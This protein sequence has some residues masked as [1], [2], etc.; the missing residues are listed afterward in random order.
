MANANRAIGVSPVTK[1][2]R[3]VIRIRKGDRF[4]YY[5]RHQGH[6]ERLPDPKDRGFAAEYSNRLVAN[7]LVEAA[8]VAVPRQV[9]RQQVYFI[10]DTATGLIKIGIAKRPGRRLNLLQVGSAS[11]LRLIGSVHGGRELERALH[12]KF[13]EHR[14]R[15]E[16]FL[17]PDSILAEIDAAFTGVAP[18]GDQSFLARFIA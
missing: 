1:L 2:P 16:W 5:F 9:I 13:Q 15:G 7:G 17:L 14:I 11:K 3:F 4:Y 18:D 8:A 6:R 10:E 12:T